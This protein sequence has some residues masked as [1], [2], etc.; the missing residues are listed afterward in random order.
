M[1][2]VQKLEFDMSQFHFYKTH[3]TL[4]NGPP[5]YALIKEHNGVSLISIGCVKEIEIVL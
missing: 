4:P 1:K 2:L 3:R 5:V